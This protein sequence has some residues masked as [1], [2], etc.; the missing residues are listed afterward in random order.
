MF[1]LR[2]RMTRGE[3]SA[4]FGRGIACVTW[5]TIWSS[6]LKTRIEGA[7]RTVTLFNYKLD[8]DGVGVARSHALSQ[9]H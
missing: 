3:P 7:L 6:A 4:G 9:R 2:P 1:S 5:N 8:V